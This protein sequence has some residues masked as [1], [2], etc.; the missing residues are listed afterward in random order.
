MELKEN[1]IVK[2]NEIKEKHKKKE[3]PKDDQVNYKTSGLLSFITF[4]WSI[5]AL[6][7][8]NKGTLQ[9][10]SIN[11]LDTVQSTRYNIV[12][13]QKN[14]EI[15][16]SNKKSKYPLMKTLFYI[17]RYKIFLLFLIDLCKILMEYLNLFFFRQIILHFSTGNF[18]FYNDI[19]E[20][21]KNMR[22]FDFDIYLSSFLFILTKFFNTILTNHME[23]RNVMLSERITNEMTAFIYEKILQSNISSNGKDEGEILSL[24]EVD[25]EKIGFLFFIGPRIVTA[26][27]RIF[28]SM[29]LLFRLFGFNFIYGILVIIFCIIIIM[30]LQIIYLRN[31]KEL[32]IKKDERSKLVTHILHIL[33]NIKINGLEEEFHEKVK[34]KRN[35]ELLYLKKNL[36]IGLIR[37]LINSNMPLILLIVSLGSYIYKYHQIEISNLFSANQLIKSLTEPLMAIPLFLNEFFSNLL[38]IDR[39]QKYLYTVDHDY[40][41]HENLEELEKNNILVQFDNCSFGLKTNLVY[42]KDEHDFRKTSIFTTIGANKE[43]VLL[44]NIN[45]KVLKGEFVAILGPT[46]SGKTCLVNAILNNYSLISSDSEPIINGVISY[47]PQINWVMNDTIKNNVLFYQE[48]DE[49]KYNN[50]IKV[51]QLSFDLQNFEDGDLTVINTNGNNISG[52][53]RARISLARSLYRDADLYLLDDPLANIDAKVGNK[54]YKEA[55]CEYLKDKT[56]IL[57]TNEF[58]HLVNCDKIIYINQ[59][60]IEFTGNYKDFI[61]KYGANFLS[62]EENKTKVK[63]DAPILHEESESEDEIDYNQSATTFNKVTEN[64]LELM[65]KS[66]LKLGKVSLETYNTYVHLQGGYI[67]FSFLIILIICARCIDSF[68]T[69]YITSWSKSIKSINL[70]N[71]KNNNIDSEKE[72]NESLDVFIYYLKISFLGIFLN[73]FIEFIVTRTTIYSLR[74]LH[75]SMIYKL[76]RAPINL[77]HDIVPIGQILSRLTKDIELVQLIIRTVTGFL[78][79]NFMLIACVYICYMYNHYT[80]IIS[81]L[82]II[83]GI[84][85]TNYYISGARNLERLHRVTFSPIINTLSESII[86][87]EVIRNCNNEN[88]LKK[89]LYNSLD[90]HYGVHIYTEGCKGWYHQMLRNC[91][92]LF[93]GII[94]SFIL[95]YPDLFSAQAIGLILQYGQDFTIELSNILENFSQIELSM[96]S[97]ER[98]EAITKIDTEKYIVEDSKRKK[99]KKINE[100]G[101]E[102]KDIWPSKGEIIFNNF[103]AQYRPTTPIILKNINFKISAGEKVGIVGR[104]GSG[105][106]SIILAICRII[107]GLE[108]NILID[109]VDITTVNLDTLR[110]NITVV[111]QDPFILEGSVKENIDP[112]NKI[113]DDEIKYIL[114]EFCILPEIDDIN[115]RIKY[116]I[117][118]NGANISIGQKQLICFARAM[119]KKTKIL[120]LDE[121]T[122]SLD[123]QTEN[124]IKRNMDKYFKDCTVI[125]ISHHIQMVSNCKKIFVIDNGELV[126]NDEYDKLLNDEKSKFYELYKESLVD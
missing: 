23:F 20:V 126:E 114:D 48:Y 82:L 77:F 83:I 115:K 122:S 17:H 22:N 104:T 76:L 49:E 31:L 56:R 44:K 38:S 59:G 107:E 123:I 120:I 30:L 1:L 121:A 96:I 14:W 52:G 57:I 26:P 75:E 34:G 43:I 16:S 13:L 111:S 11:A 46:G 27:I 32:L 86:G 98:C 97:L 74:T 87:V 116:K 89:K 45:L 125:M 21:I 118:E 41:K 33:K 105:K 73:F 99:N 3:V 24:I 54:I 72:L 78:K 90:D 62:K 50:I 112:T 117:R 5:K 69:I 108:G 28:I 40:T 51:S 67:I 7:L 37:M 39:I 80:L 35:E 65:N 110:Q 93:Y 2:S 25:C 103:S 106:S 8:S 79:S 6:S 66:K 15:F 88:N 10:E 102:M 63:A 47:T 71:N 113:S 61:S 124:I 4:S 119:L 92:H 18:K 36:N 95:R 53:Q 12:P 58:T 100:K 42:S 9:I 55:F 64:P 29:D 81:P 85:L 91:S 94:L 70:N 19:H 84:L 68:R 101:E 60:K 109:N